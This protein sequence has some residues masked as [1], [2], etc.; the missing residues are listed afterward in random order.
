MGAR[1]SGPPRNLDH[2]LRYLLRPLGGV[3]GDL[4]VWGTEQGHGTRSPTMRPNDPW[5][6]NRRGAPFP[7]VAEGF[8]G[9]V[10]D[11]GPSLR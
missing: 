5:Y 10:E 4:K 9:Q 8:R 11:S 1:C 6:L 7:T 3:K 2:L